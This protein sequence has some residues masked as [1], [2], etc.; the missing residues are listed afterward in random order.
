MTR[1]IQTNRCTN[2][3]ASAF[4]IEAKTTIVHAYDLT[5]ELRE[6]GF[7]VEK[8]KTQV[9]HDTV[10]CNVEYDDDNKYGHWECAYYDY[11]KMVDVLA[12]W[13]EG[14]SWVLFNPGHVQAVL[15]DGSIVDTYWKPQGFWNRKIDSAYKVS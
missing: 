9:L 4:G 10:K 11:K 2:T 6:A 13:T 7:T 5:D 8:I 3:V 12:D 15:A 14:E 1:P